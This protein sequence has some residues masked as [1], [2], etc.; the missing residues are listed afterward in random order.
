MCVCVCVWGG[1][2]GYSG[3]VVSICVLMCFMVVCALKHTH[4]MDTICII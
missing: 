1:G 4:S 2:D 3:C